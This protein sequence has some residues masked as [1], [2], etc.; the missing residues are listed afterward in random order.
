[1]E[2]L[3]NYLKFAMH[4]GQIESICLFTRENHLVQYSNINT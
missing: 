2:S 3:P 1:M 4:K